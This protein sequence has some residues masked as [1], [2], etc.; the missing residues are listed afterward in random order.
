M[1]GDGHDRLYG[2]QG[3]DVLNGGDGSDRL[4]GDAG[5]D[6]LYGG[7]GN[8]LMVGGAGRDTLTGGQ[9]RDRFTYLSRNDFQD[10]IS[11]FEILKDRIDLSHIQGIS[12]MRDL[13]L[14]QQG[15]DVLLKVQAGAGFQLAATL[16]D[17]QASTLKQGHFIL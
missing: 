17:V 16:E 8:D 2:K 3:N 13:R 12:S 9:G 10:V 4:Y 15:D 14:V 1:G 7:R 6:R 11:D 5:R